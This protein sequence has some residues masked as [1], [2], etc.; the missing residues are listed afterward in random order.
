MAIAERADAVIELVTEPGDFVARGICCFVYVVVVARSMLPLCVPVSP[1]VPAHDATGSAFR[2]PHHGGHRQQ[3]PS[4]AINDPTTAVLALD[5]IH[6]LLMYVGKRGLD[7][8]QTRD[9]QG[10]LRLYYGTPDWTDFVSWRSQKFAIM[11][12]A[13]CRWYARLHAMLAY[14]LHVMPEA[15]EG[16]VAAVRA[17][18]S[19]LDRAIQRNFPDDAGLCL[20]SCWRFPRHRQFRAVVASFA[21][22]PAHWRSEHNQRRRA[23][24]HDR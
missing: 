9:A 22:V 19:L 3:A 18:V 23:P 11:P 24:C 16:R 15:P 20:R 4:P 17:A 10:Q 2:I 21:C 6:R 8:G 5:Q 7:A 14:L 13:T 12:P 1:S